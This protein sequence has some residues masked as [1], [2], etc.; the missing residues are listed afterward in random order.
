MFTLIITAALLLLPARSHIRQLAHEHTNASEFRRC[1]SDDPGS[2]AA[3]LRVN[4]GIGR[5]SGGVSEDVRSQP[6]TSIPATMRAVQ[7]R[8]YDGNPEVNVN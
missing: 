8:A 2:M 6:V 4:V 3:K 7:L 1:F 5:W